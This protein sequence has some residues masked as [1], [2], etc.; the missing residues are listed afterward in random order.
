MEAYRAALEERRRDRV[1]LDWAN[2]QYNLSLV[3]LALFDKTQDPTHL[4]QAEA[5]VQAAREVFVE[6]NTPH[7]IALADD[8]LAQ[9]NRRR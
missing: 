2:T 1:P 4:E 8:Q 5:H 6:A 3:E 7:Y 9:I